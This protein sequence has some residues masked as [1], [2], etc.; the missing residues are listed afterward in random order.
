MRIP[1]I[2]FAPLVLFA[3]APATSAPIRFSSCE[4]SHRVTCVVDGDTFW[5]DGLKIR[6]ADINAPETGHP[7]CASEAR[8]GMAATRR[9]TEL[10][11]SGPFALETQGRDKDRYGRSLRVVVRN[12]QS[13]GL[14]LEREG[15]AEHWKGRRGNWCGV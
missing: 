7:S 5:L 6:I 4:G 8:L 9:L 1:M 12:G 13:I 3:A 11:N 10:L 14:T 2:F 15:L